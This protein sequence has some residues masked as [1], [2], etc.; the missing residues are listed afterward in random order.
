MFFFIKVVRAL[1]QMKSGGSGASAASI[2]EQIDQS[3]NNDSAGDCEVPVGPM[4]DDRPTQNTVRVKKS[5]QQSQTPSGQN[6]PSKRRKT[7]E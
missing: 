6:S 4:S 3:L 2:L 7:G 1:E 5:A